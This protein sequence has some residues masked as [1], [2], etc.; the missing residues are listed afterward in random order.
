MKVVGIDPG[1]NGGIAIVSLNGFR[2]AEVFEMLEIHEFAELMELN[3]NTISMVFIEKQQPYPKQGVVSTGNLMKHYGEL[4]GVLVA[5][6]IPFKEV[7]PKEWQSVMMG[8]KHKKKS[9]RE[10]KR[11]S[12]RRAK[13][14]FPTVEIGNKD[15]IAEALLIAEY[16]RVYLG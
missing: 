5:L 4:I 15:G 2:D 9:R 10:K 13:E 14:V 16:G 12:I 11:A 7:R 3:K 8:S 1:K 6:K